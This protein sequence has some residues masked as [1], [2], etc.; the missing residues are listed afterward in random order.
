MCLNN[1]LDTSSGVPVR[2][3]KEDALP[4]TQPHR[5]KGRAPRRHGMICE[6]GGAVIVLKQE[7]GVVFWGGGGCEGAEIELEQWSS[8]AGGRG[9]LLGGGRGWSRRFAVISGWEGG[10]G[11]LR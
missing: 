7:T 2:V 11:D 1:G 5:R 8:G 6:G 3:G 10:A 4:H 9:N